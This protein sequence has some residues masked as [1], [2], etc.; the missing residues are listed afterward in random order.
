MKPWL[1][2]TY[3]RE[4][5]F[6]FQ[7]IHQVFSHLL[8]EYESSK[9]R[10]MQPHAEGWYAINVWSILIDKIFLNI[11]NIELVRGESVALHQAT[12]RTMTRCTG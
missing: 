12:E 9:N 2:T 1:N 8:D 7:Y 6:D 3:N 5:H 10:L 11:P 4:E